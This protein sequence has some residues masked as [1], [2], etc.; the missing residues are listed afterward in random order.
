MTIQVT[1]VLVLTLVI[2]IVGTL[3]YSV[4]IVGVKTGRIAIAFAIFNVFALLS[5]TANTFQAPLLAKTIEKSIEGGNTDGMLH[6]FRWILLSA[7][8][9]TIIGA[10]LLPTFMRVFTKAVE[11]FSVYRSVPRLILHGFSKSGIEQFK[12]SITIP[13]KDNLSQLK[14]LRKIPKKIVLLNVI[15]SSISTVGVLASLYAGCLYPEFRTTCSTLS[16]AINGVATILM[17]LFIDPYISMMTDDVIKGECTELDFSRCVIFI[18]CGLIVGTM[19]A[20][21]LLVPAAMAIA[22]IARV[23]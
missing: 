13:K 8:L 19:L 22:S 1:A 11:S 7:T 3:A 17:F 9:A 16:S 23:I 18:V 4:R 15:T 20:Q 14:S 21:L 10:M 6:I 12:R 2:Y 5:R